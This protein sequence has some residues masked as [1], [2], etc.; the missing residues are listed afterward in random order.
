[1]TLGWQFSGT[2]APLAFVG[3]WSVASFCAW[4]GCCVHRAMRT[5]HMYPLPHVRSNLFRDKAAPGSVIQIGKSAYRRIV[6]IA[7][8]LGLSWVLA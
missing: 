6:R 2:R 4:R 5:D 8:F 1:M 3:L 7:L